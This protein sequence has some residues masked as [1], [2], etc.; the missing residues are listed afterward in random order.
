MRKSAILSRKWEEVRV[1]DEYPY[2]HMPKKDSK[3]RRANRLPLPGLCVLAL[4]Q[5][6]SY[7][8]LERYKHFSPAFKQQ[9]VELIAGQLWEGLATQKQLHRRKKKKAARMSG[10]NPLIYQDLKAEPTGLEPATSDVTGRRSNQLNYDS[11]LPS[12]IILPVRPLAW[13]YLMYK[14]H[15]Y[16]A[17]TSAR[18][19]HSKIGSNV[20]DLAGSVSRLYPR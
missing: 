4:R 8:E 10:F 11:T 7:V 19:G 12:P 16:T 6:P 14:N 2:I 15:H 5:L 18:L 13:Q 1:D 17:A 3:N 20:Q 9:T